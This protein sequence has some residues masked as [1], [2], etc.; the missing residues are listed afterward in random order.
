MI[1]FC[2]QKQYLQQC[3]AYEGF[4]ICPEVIKGIGVYYG[5]LNPVGKG[6]EKFVEETSRLAVAKYNGRPH[7]P[8]VINCCV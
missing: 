4:H 2:L 3:Y 8:K 7:R 1:I 5:S 6:G